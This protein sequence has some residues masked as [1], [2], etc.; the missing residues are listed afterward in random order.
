LDNQ[1]RTVGYFNSPQKI[2]FWLLPW[3]G[4]FNPI[5]ACSWYV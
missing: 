2:I 4:N 5:F 1:K 3:D